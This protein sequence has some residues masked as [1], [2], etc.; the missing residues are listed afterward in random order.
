MLVATWLNTQDVNADA[1]HEAELFLWQWPGIRRGK[2][3]QW[4]LTAEAERR[5][6]F[7]GRMVDIEG[8]AIADSEGSSDLSRDRILASSN[9]QVQP[10]G[11]CR[12]DGP[13]FLLDACLICPHFITSSSFLPA[14]NRKVEE[15]ESKLAEAAAANNQRLA[16][17]CR[18]A[19][20]GARSIIQVL[21]T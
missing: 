7:T 8:R 19:L 13:C 16:D 1:R 9:L 21:D 3:G 17:S 20:R 11:Y 4:S 10:F 6:H 2:D 15:L 14:L 18:H 5:R 12:K